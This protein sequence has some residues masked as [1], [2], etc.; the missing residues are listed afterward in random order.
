M[1]AKT[2]LPSKN[3]DATKTLEAMT[4]QR[5]SVL[6]ATADQVAALNDALSADA[7]K[8]E[9]S[10]EFDLSTLRAGVLIGS[11]SATLG[12]ISFKPIA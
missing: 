12:S 10:R 1:G 8:P 4:T 6:V 3:F 9:A 2:L 11:G 7:A 5:A